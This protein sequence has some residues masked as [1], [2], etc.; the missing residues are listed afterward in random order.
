MVVRTI[1]FKLL[2]G[3]VILPQAGRP[4][5]RIAMT[6]NPT[7]ECLAWQV[8]EAFPW[9][10]APGKCVVCGRR[11]TVRRFSC[12]ASPTACLAPHRP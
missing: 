7:A 11:A 10:E 12:G 1:A 9:D 6:S 4:R 2:Y 8:T 5:V 3:L